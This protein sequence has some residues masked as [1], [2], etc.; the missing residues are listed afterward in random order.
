MHREAAAAAG[1]G[2]ADVALGPSCGHQLL[3]SPLPPLTPL[4]PLRWRGNRRASRGSCGS[5]ESG[6]AITPSL[7]R[8]CHLLT[9]TLIRWLKSWH[10]LPCG[11]GLLRQRGAAVMTPSLRHGYRLLT[12]YYYFAGS[13]AGARCGAAQG[14]Y[15]RGRSGDADAVAPSWVPQLLTSTT[16]SLASILACAAVRREA[17]A[18]ARGAAVLTP[19]L[20]RNTI[21][22]LLLKFASSRAGTRAALWRE[23]AAAARGGDS[24]AVAPS[25]VAIAHYY[26][27][28]AS[29]NAGARC[30]A[31]PGFCVGRE[32][33]CYHRRTDVGTG[34]REY[35]DSPRRP[36]CQQRTTRLRHHWH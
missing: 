21:Y 11:A 14:C 22:S 16:T 7:R 4:P 20:H 30:G 18:A 15:S 9:S 2:S 32:P 10:G 3:Y 36:L 31:A 23:A 26:C 13:R 33:R 19:S 35:T 12:I 6:S 28:C 17:T 5:K 8:G 25:W 34:H 24:N 1:T 27:Y 29:F